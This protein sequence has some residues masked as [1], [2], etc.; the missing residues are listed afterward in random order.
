[1]IKI[2]Y[3]R[4]N[5]FLLGEPNAKIEDCNRGRVHSW[6]GD[7]PSRMY[8]KKTVYV[9]FHEIWAIWPI[10]KHKNNKIHHQQ[11][12]NALLL[13]EQM[14]ILKITHDALY[15]KFHAIR[16]LHVFQ[17]NKIPGKFQVNKNAIS[18]ERIE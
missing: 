5:A 17:V 10:I 7:S 13:G 8:V 12:R 3:Q 1:M 6:V 2:H 14:Q 9:K 15:V 11:R 4:R 16:V 18:R